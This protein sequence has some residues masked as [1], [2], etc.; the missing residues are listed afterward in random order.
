MFSM[1]KINQAMSKRISDELMK[2]ANSG[3][4]EGIIRV[5]KNSVNMYAH[6]DYARCVA[7][8][9]ECALVAFALLQCGAN[10]HASN[11]V[12]LQLS[13]E[14]GNI[15]TVITLLEWG[16]NVHANDDA[17]LRCSAKK[18]YTKIVSALL[19]YGADVCARDSEA[20]IESAVCAKFE[21]VV[22]LLEYIA[23]VDRPIKIFWDNILF[24]T[25]Y[26]YLTIITSEVT[27]DGTYA[28]IDTENDHLKI[29]AKLLECGADIYA[30]SDYV[31]KQICD[32]ICICNIFMPEP[33][34][35]DIRTYMSDPNDV[36]M[37]NVGGVGRRVRKEFEKDLA[38]VILPYC[39]ATD[40]HYFPD[41]YI[42]E[43]VIITK[44]ARNV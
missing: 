8:Q 34:S 10:V 35:N 37:C 31:L 32:N 6:D 7:A 24:N 13:A 39:H 29:I 26:A 33:D 25:V 42:K 9:I 40:Y 43:N 17:A 4:I 14:N 5:L 36:C 3:N 30:N 28:L 18:G 21:V 44:G 19:E 20:L 2:H 27:K 22:K 41:V 1:T 11:D 15:Q 16:A 12:A 38:D 23:N